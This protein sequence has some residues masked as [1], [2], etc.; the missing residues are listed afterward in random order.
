MV[1]GNGNSGAPL[2]LTLPEATLEAIAQRA[3]EL[4]NQ[5]AADPSSPWLT[6]AEAAE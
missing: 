2:E 5:S 6:T 3:A 1:Q 4:V